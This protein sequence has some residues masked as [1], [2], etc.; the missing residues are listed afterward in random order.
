MKYRININTHYESWIDLGEFQKTTVTDI[1]FLRVPE[2]TS[3]FNTSRS[4]HYY[5]REIHLVIKKK[6]NTPVTTTGSSVL[7]DCNDFP[8]V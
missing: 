6:K 7:L 5:L 8:K 1:H 4:L 2:R 3:D